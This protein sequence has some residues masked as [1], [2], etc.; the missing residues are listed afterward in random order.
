METS[1]RFTCYLNY[2]TQDLQTSVGY[3][4]VISQNSEKIY[5]DKQANIKTSATDH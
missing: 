2:L 3:T 5:K 4:K 1:T